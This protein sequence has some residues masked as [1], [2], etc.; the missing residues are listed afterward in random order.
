MGILKAKLLDFFLA[1]SIFRIGYPIMSS[2]LILTLIKLDPNQ[3]GFH[4]R[5]FFSVKASNEWDTAVAQIRVSTLAC[6]DVPLL[7]A[8]ALK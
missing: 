3:R 5:A 4:L 8:V 6:R 7:R 2:L 1:T